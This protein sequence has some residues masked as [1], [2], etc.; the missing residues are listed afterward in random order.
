MRKG[1]DLEIAPPSYSHAGSGY[2][3]DPVFSH[4]S[5]PRS[6]FRTSSNDLGMPPP[7]SQFLLAVDF[8][9]PESACTARAEYAAL[10]HFD[11]KVGPGRD[12]AFGLFEVIIGA[13]P[14]F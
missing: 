6:S 8:G 2:F 11:D 9:R 5:S 4:A 3:S 10:L 14:R 12:I 1:A 7:P 13:S